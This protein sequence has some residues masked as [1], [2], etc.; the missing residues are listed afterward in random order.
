MNVIKFRTTQISGIPG[1][2]T[3]ALDE[4]TGSVYLKQMIML[5]KENPNWTDDLEHCKIIRE[6]T[7]YI[8]IERAVHF[9]RNTFGSILGAISDLI[10][11]N[12]VLTAYENPTKSKEIG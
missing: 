4:E 3:V 1:K 12:E 9:H 7:R 6:S 8:V 2:V 11:K 5:S 10:E